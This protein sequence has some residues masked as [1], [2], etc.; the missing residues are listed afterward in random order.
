MSKKKPKLPSLTHFS[1]VIGGIL[2]SDEEAENAMLVAAVYLVA[3]DDRYVDLS[4]RLRMDL[5]P[6]VLEAIVESVEEACVRASEENAGEE[7]DA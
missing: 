4:V 6:D 2:L 1:R 3:E 5:E 7:W